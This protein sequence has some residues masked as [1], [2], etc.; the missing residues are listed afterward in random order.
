VVFPF[1]LLLKQYR[2][3]DFQGSREKRTRKGAIPPPA[4]FFLA[5]E[6]DNFIVSSGEPWLSKKRSGF[7]E[8]F[9][10][11]AEVQER[12]VEVQGQKE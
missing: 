8:A 5:F 7:G 12:S 2:T 1:D 9:P 11:N 3:R 4:N 10:K 6:L